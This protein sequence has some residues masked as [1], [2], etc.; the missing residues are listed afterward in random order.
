MLKQYLQYKLSQKLSPQQIQ[1]MKLIQLSTLGFEQRIQEELEENPALESGKEE[2]E[3][4][5]KIDPITQVLDVIR[6]KQY[7]TDSEITAID[8]RVRNLVQ[9][10]EEFAENSEFPPIEQL[11]DVVYEQRDYPFLAHKL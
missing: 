4:Y 7:A 10:C 3:E 2:V 8:E 6:E 11:Y 5:K 1:P 9:E